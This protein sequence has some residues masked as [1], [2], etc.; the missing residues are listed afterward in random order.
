[1]EKYR[2][3]LKF[4]IRICAIYCI[5]MLL[6]NIVLYHF[7]GTTTFS[8]F[9]QGI[10]AAFQAIAIALIAIYG[11]ALKSEEQLKKLYIRSKDERRT[12]I[13]SKVASTGIYIILGGLVLVVMIS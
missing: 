8:G 2:E 10:M 5:L 7:L 3:T 11:T 13:K 9:I 1:M 6:P 12:F 4:R